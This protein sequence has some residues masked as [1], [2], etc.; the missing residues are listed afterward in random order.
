M[1]ATTL[2]RTYLSSLRLEEINM[3]RNKFLKHLAEIWKCAVDFY[4][5]VHLSLCKENNP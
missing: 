5:K 4:K 2:H 3:L 1:A